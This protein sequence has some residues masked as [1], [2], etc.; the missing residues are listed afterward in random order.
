MTTAHDDIELARGVVSVLRQTR[1]GFPR[2]APPYGTE[3]LKL[4]TGSRAER[5][6]G[7]AALAAA[8][9][10]KVAGCRWCLATAH[11]RVNGAP[12]PAFSAATR[13]LLG[14]PCRDCLGRMRAELSAKVR[15]GEVAARTQAMIASAIEQART[16]FTVGDAESWRRWVRQDPRHRDP[17]VVGQQR[18]VFAAEEAQ[19]RARLRGRSL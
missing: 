11:A 7:P 8:A 10:F 1:P 18:A 13:V 4:F 14:E 6:F 5:V 19:R 16:P 2:S 17:A 12:A 3:A 9:P 15:R